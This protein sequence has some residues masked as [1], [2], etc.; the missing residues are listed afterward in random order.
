MRLSSIG[1]EEAETLLKTVQ[2]CRGQVYLKTPDGDLFNLKSSFSQYI[3]LRELLQESAD[4]LELVAE[5]MADWDT[6]YGLV[7]TLRNR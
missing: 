3:A 2:S 4:R 5:D 7:R 6:V 1:P